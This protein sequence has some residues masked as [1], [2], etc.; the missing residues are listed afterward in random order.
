MQG[1]ENFIKQW[2]NSEKALHICMKQEQNALKRTIQ[3]TKIK[4]LLESKQKI[5]GKDVSG[6]WF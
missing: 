6:N 1:E 5:E 4:E 3:R 2:Y